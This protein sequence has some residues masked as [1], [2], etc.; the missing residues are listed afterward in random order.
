MSY[1]LC[2]LYVQLYEL[3]N[4]REDLWG[5]RRPLGVWGGAEGASEAN[6]SP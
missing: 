6:V 1:A 5:F 2:L 4:N 3:S